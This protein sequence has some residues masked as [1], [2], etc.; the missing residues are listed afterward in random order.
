[1]EATVKWCQHL[2]IVPLICSAINW[3]YT[4]VSEQ[5][6]HR[7]WSPSPQIPDPGFIR[8]LWFCFHSCFENREGAD[9]RWWRSYKRGVGAPA[10]SIR[11]SFMDRA[12]VASGVRCWR[13]QA[14]WNRPVPS[15]WRRVQ[16]KFEVPVKAG[17]TLTRLSVFFSWV[18]AADRPAGEPNASWAGHRLLHN[19]NTTRKAP[20]IHTFIQL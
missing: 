10:A 7:P 4:H 18:C 20:L 14:S 6:L 17:E 8:F 9:E 1:M 12:D 2:L 3:I 13:T 11:C 16:L 15:L 5:I 19:R